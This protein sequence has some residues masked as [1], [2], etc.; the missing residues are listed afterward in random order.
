MKRE[1]LTFKKFTAIHETFEELELAVGLVFLTNIRPYLTSDILSIKELPFWDSGN[2]SRKIY[3]PRAERDDENKSKGFHICLFAPIYGEDYAEI[4]FRRD[5]SRKV[6]FLFGRNEEKRPFGFEEG[7]EH[8]PL[9]IYRHGSADWRFNPVFILIEDNKKVR[10]FKIS[11]I[12]IE[13]RVIVGFPKPSDCPS[14][15]V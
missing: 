12:W 3:L 14:F 10:L 5:V 1:D 15:L 13:D 11:L 9:R 8:L 2:G 7:K 4:V 6:K